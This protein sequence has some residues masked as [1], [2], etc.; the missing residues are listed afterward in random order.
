MCHPSSPHLN[1]FFWKVCDIRCTGSGQSI[2]SCNHIYWHYQQCMHHVPKRRRRDRI[3]EFRSS[4][5]R[6]NL[7]SVR[8]SYNLRVVGKHVRG[9]TKHFPNNTM[10]KKSLSSLCRFISSRM[11]AD[12]EAKPRRSCHFFATRGDPTAHWHIAWR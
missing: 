2:I 1:Y 8:I 11:I 10:T 4:G 5:S 6:K 12:E 7:R 3:S 9:R